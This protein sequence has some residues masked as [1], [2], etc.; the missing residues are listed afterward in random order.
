MFFGVGLSRCGP[1]RPAPRP[2]PARSYVAPGRG[3][4]GAL[5][6]HSQEK[7]QQKNPRQRSLRRAGSFASPSSVPAPSRAASAAHSGRYRGLLTLVVKPDSWQTR[8]RADKRHH[9]SAPI[10]AAESH[11]LANARLFVGYRPHPHEA[12]ESHALADA[13]SFVGLPPHTPTASRR[14]CREGLAGSTT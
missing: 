7:P 5:V 6:C 13:R 11:S 9:D 10:N 2:K 8:W 4:R 14:C 3:T 12:A 1:P